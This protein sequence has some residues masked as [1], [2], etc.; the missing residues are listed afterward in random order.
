V[1]GLAPPISDYQ[2][3]SRVSWLHL[4]RDEHVMKGLFPV[5][6]PRCYG[7]ELY[8][9]HEEVVIGYIGVEYLKEEPYSQGNE[10]QLLR[11]TAASIEI[12]LLQPL[13]HL[14][15]REEE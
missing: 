3:S 9:R 8:D 4:K 11:Q 5:L 14:N 2:D 6:L 7:M 15:S 10:M 1:E 12:G 13:E